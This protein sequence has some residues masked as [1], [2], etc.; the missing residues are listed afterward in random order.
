MADR[1]DFYE[2][3]CLRGIAMC[4]VF[5]IHAEGI[6]NWPRPVPADASLLRS[7]IYGGH[8]APTLFFVLS[9]FL[10]SRPFLAELRGGRRVNLPN[11]FARRALRI[12]PLYALAV[13]VGIAVSA[14]TLLAAVEALP[15][16]V[17]GQIVPGL[18]PQMDPF[19]GPWWTVCTEVEFYLLLPLLAFAARSRRGRL[20]ALAVF[21]AYLAVYTAFAISDLGLPK[22]TRFIAA[23]SVLGRGPAFLVGILAAVVLIAG[24]SARASSGCGTAGVP[25]S[26]ATC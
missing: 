12:V 22:M 4:L 24:G 7:Y 1:E 20:A 13:L 16:L 2:L 26:R 11:Y 10:L 17:F 5:G 8:T 15:Y 3:D 14:P 21:V 23:H 9:A 6:V 18:V 19:S 25:A